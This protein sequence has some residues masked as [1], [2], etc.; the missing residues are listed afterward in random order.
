MTT[1][2]PLAR[3]AFASLEI[4]TAT[5]PAETFTEIG[6]IETLTPSF[7]STDADTSDYDSDG[8][9]EHL[10][11]ERTEQI[12]ISGHMAYTDVDTGERDPGQ[13]AVEEL[14]RKT[15][16]DSVGKIVLNLL[17]GGSIE[18]DVTATLGNQGGPR[19]S[20]AQWGVTFTSTGAPT[21]V[22]AT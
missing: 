20:G 16:L 6:G 22:P 1:L 10:V 14:A 12:Q 11:A 18:W 17:G 15:G 4:L 8:W 3:E 5:D 13:Q 9:T 7:Q 21:I 2:K 19:G